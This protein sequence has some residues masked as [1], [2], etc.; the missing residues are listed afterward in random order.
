MRGSGFIAWC[1]LL[2]IAAAGLLPCACDEAAPAGGP[3]DVRA[4]FG[5]VGRFPGQFSYPRGMDTHGGALVIVDK[6]ARIQRLDA[7]TGRFLGGWRMPEF[8][9]GKPTGVTVGPHPFEAGRAV[10]YVADTHYHRIVAY[11]LPGDPLER[12]GPRIAET[13]PAPVLEIG[14]YGT[15][16][17][18][19]VYPTDVAVL[20]SEEPHE[21]VARIYVSEYGGNDRITVF[22]RVGDGFEIAF[23]FGTPGHGDGA[24]G[25]R[26]GVEFHR[27]QSMAIEP[28]R[29]ELIITDSGNHRI[30]RFTLDGALIAWMSPTGEDNTPLRYPYGLALLQ[31][32]TAL[33]SEFGGNRI[34]RFD[35]AGRRFLGI[36]GTAGRGAGEL[37]SPWAVAVSGRTAFALDSGNNR[38]LAF[39]SPAPAL[40]IAAWEESP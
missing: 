3:L 34:R 37:F 21:P 9:L 13:T 7:E 31:D 10:V 40:D 20:P 29:R 19:F 33:V 1:R 15:D 14:G 38:V 24:A 35:P 8:E 30:G 4:Q 25:R 28:T 26:A 17:G 12:T 16:P 36:Y 39:R 23:T 18:S 11:P 32:G 5:E 6:S 22:E 2:L 27:P